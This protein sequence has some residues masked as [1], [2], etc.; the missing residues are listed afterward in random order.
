MLAWDY[1]Q[2]ASKNDRESF[3]HCL[4]FAGN[5]FRLKHIVYY[6]ATGLNPANLDRGK[7]GSGKA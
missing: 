5:S 4:K 6:G 7:I 3:D 1:L 2:R